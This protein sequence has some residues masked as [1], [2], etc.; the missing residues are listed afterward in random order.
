[1]PANSLRPE[2]IGILG[3]TFDPIHVGHLVA[4]QAVRETL[5]LDRILLIPSGTPP[6]KDEDSVS[7][8]SVRLR[9]VRAAVAGDPWF[10]VA[11]LELRREGPSYTVDTLRALTEAHPATAYFL[12]M[13]S[14]QWRKFGE[15]RDPWAISS[16]ATLVVMTRNGEDPDSV[17]PGLP[18]DSTGCTRIPVRPVAVPRIDLSSSR[19][20]R[21]TRAGESVRYMVPESVHRILE[22]SRL[23]L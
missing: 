18:P 4:A 3:G 16:L 9:M 2:R 23:Y 13:G 6:H 7:S 20:R 11:D 22:A 15:W 1:M 5:E 21:R 12:I 19:I 10:E 8:A 17:D 14:D